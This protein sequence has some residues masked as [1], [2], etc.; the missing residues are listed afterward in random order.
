MFVL[1]ADVSLRIVAAAA[2]V[3]VVLVVLRVRSG[4]ARQAAWS[5]VL[6][7]MLTMPVLVAIVPDRRSRRALT[8]SRRERS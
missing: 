3:G 8:T 2:A 7:A 5:A 6:L 1:A 4:A